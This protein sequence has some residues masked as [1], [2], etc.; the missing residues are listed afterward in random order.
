MGN[1]MRSG[2]RKSRNSSSK[3]LEDIKTKDAYAHLT[4][5]HES[6]VNIYDT[7]MKAVLNNTNGYTVKLKGAEDS[8]LFLAETVLRLNELLQTKLGDEQ[9]DIVSG[10]IYVQLIQAGIIVNKPTE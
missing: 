10:N 7:V 9:L 4:A 6:M 3:K 2:N 1:F 5:I 8:M